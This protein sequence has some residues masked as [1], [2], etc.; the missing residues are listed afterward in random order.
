MSE[1]KI[2][3]QLPRSFESQHFGEKHVVSCNKIANSIYNEM[4]HSHC[5]CWTYLVF[6]CSLL[7]ASTIDNDFYSVIRMPMKVFS[8]LVVPVCKRGVFLCLLIFS[9]SLI[10]SRYLSHHFGEFSDCTI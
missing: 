3:L 9:Y 6:G 2:N 7:T 4:K 1:E 5:T 8:R 10:L